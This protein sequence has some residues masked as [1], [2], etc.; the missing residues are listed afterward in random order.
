VYVPVK[1]CD[2]ADG[3][4]EVLPEGVAT[5][6]VATLEDGVEEGVKVVNSPPVDA[7]LLEGVV[8]CV[9]ELTTFK[10]PPNVGEAIDDE[11]FSDDWVEDDDNEDSV[12]DEFIVFSVV[13]P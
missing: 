1:V 10:S 12:V 11:V 7:L 9:D 13:L 2:S 5:V 3:E 6:V 4:D 8:S